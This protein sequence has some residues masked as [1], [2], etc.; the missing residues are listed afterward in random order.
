MKGLVYQEFLRSRKVLIISTIGTIC[1]GGIFVLVA[2]SFR[3]GNLALLPEVAYQGFFNLNNVVSLPILAL[4][5]GFVIQSV[6]SSTAEDNLLNRMF[7]RSTPVSALRYAAAKYILMA[8]YF[9]LGLAL[10]YA[11]SLSFCAVSQIEF[12][13]QNHAMLFMCVEFTLLFCVLMTVA[14]ALLRISRDKA[15]LILMITFLGLIAIPGFI[16]TVNNVELDLST[17]MLFDF[18]MAI[19]PFSALVI[20]GI[21]AAGLFLTAYAYKRSE[22]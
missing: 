18:S 11:L 16:L 20:V 9:V 7:R 13:V 22:K 6:D 2:L 21:L 5:S 10:A 4:V 15:G 1:M 19:F 14:Q 3:V 17:D 12:T 8:A